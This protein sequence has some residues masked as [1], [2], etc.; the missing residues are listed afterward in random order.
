M[1]AHHA[2]LNGVDRGRRDGRFYLRKVG[3]PMGVADM[4]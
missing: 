2:V 4:L 1:Q 3:G